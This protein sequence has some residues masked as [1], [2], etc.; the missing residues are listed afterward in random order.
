MCMEEI[1]G[2]DALLDVR[3]AVCGDGAAV[4]HGMHLKLF[5][6][7]VRDMGHTGADLESKKKREG[8]RR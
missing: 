1:L 8:W 3:G 2:H 5:V 6:V 7:Q 4:L